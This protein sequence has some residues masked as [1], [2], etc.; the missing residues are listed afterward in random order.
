MQRFALLL[1]LLLTMPNVTYGSSTADINN[2]LCSGEYSSSLQGNA[3]FLCVG[4]LSLSNGFIAS[5]GKVIISS[6]GSLF[7]DDLQITAPI[8]EI[9]SLQG[10]T[11]GSSVYFYSDFLGSSTSPSITLTA[12]SSLTIGSGIA[13]ELISGGDVNITLGAGNQALIGGQVATIDGGNI[14][15]TP[16]P[17][18]TSSALLFSGILL[19]LVLKAGRKKP[20][21]NAIA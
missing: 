18:P 1:L 11:I 14:S 10:V 9:Y 16:V 19:C 13:V 20:L 3:S 8:I 4:D 15:L 21:E 7:I 12:G 5:D 6:E 2:A 17:L